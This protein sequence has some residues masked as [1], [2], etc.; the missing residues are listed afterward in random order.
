MLTSRLTGSAGE[1]VAMA[2]R[3][4]PDARSFGEATAGVPTG[5]TLHRLQDG[6]GLVLTEGIGVDRTGRTYETRIRPDQPVASDWTRYG[7]AADPV[8]DAATKWLD[9]RCRGR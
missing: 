2:F 1:G 6:A 8:V 9:G 7:T 3:G 4:R 5:N